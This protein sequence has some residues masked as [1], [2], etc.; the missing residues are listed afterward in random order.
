M[1]LSTAD[2]PSPDRANS[3]ADNGLD[4]WLMR[5][6][7]EQTF[8]QRDPPELMASR[9]LGSY[10]GDDGF[11]FSLIGTNGGRYVTE[12]STDWVSWE[13]FSTNTAST[14]DV[15]LLDPSAAPRNRTYYR[16]R[17]VSP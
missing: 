10:L 1:V 9:F 5:F 7:P 8:V 6:T 11:R 4:L 14:S 12:R 15:K 2:G 16:S 3:S 17:A 13:P